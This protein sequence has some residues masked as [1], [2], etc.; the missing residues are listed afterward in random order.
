VAA[1]KHLYAPARAGTKRHLVVSNY[2][3]LYAVTFSYAYINLSAGTGA[4]ILFCSVK[5]N[6]ILYGLWTGERPHLLQWSGFFIAFGG[7]VYLVLPSI[8][9]PSLIGS[10]A[11][12]R[13]WYWMGDLLI[14]RPGCEGSCPHDGE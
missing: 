2:G 1:D 14:A 12:G 10:L 8:A 4:L 6:M 3:V 9:A 13:C 11:H 7:L 5:V